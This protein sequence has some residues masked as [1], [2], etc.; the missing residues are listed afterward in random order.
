MTYSASFTVVA[1]PALL[2]S[3]CIASQKPYRGNG[4]W[5]TER[6]VLES[7]VVMQPII[8]MGHINGDGEL[9]LDH[10]H[11]EFIERKMQSHVQKAIQKKLPDVHVR[12]LSREQAGT[13]AMATV[14]AAFEKINR[15]IIGNSYALAPRRISSE[16]VTLGNELQDAGIDADAAVFVWAEDFRI[17][18]SYAVGKLGKEIARA[19]LSSSGEKP[20]GRRSSSSE[21]PRGISAAVVQ[22]SSGAILWFNYDE[23]D[24]SMG[25]EKTH[26]SQRF[27]DE[28][29]RGL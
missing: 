7:V 10:D 13:P 8:S 14:H 24:W 25:L 16:R 9:K 29:L 17:D 28:L 12:A 21:Y 23:Y 22:V 6:A 27:V 26:E 15:Y 18:G 4:Q 1:T 5:S 11:A 3:G 19:L 20:V 2:F